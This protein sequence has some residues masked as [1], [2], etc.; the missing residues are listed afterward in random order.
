MLFILVPGFTS[1][2]IQL[3]AWQNLMAPNN[4]Y[5]TFLIRD[6][7]HL[8]QVAYWISVLF[9][10]TIIYTRL[11]TSPDRP[12]QFDHN[13]QK[14]SRAY[15]FVWIL[16]SNSPDL[17]VLIAIIQFKQLIKNQNGL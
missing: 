15:G 9:D 6:S 11:D 16:Q 4:W 3:R 5:M 2:W 10:P 1:L 14:P 17:G 12:T 13:A 7:G 8:E